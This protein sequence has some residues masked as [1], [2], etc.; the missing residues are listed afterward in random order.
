MA[1]FGDF[2]L[3]IWGVGGCQIS[4]Q[5]KSCNWRLV[6]RYSFQGFAVVHSPVPTISTLAVL[7][8]QGKC[9]FGIPRMNFREFPGSA[10]FWHSYSYIQETLSFQEFSGFPGKGFWGSR[11]TFSG[12][13]EVD[14]LGSGACPQRHYQPENMI[15]KSMWDYYWSQNTYTHKKNIGELIS[16]LHTHKLHKNNSEGINCVI[17]V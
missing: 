16:K 3:L 7:I 15:L 6:G 12:G 4:C 5:F 9:P 10:F 17:F 8:R 14:M 2:F 1:Y 11:L 13:D